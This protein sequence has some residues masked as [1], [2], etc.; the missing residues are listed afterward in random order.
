MPA[1]TR[2]QEIRNGGSWVMSIRTKRTA[3]GWNIYV[4]TERGEN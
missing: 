3:L 4:Y 2:R 1:M